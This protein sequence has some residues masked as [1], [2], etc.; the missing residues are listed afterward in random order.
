M[1]EMDLVKERIGYL[2]VWIGIM[3]IANISL[4]GWLIS[5]F[6]TSDKSIVFF[7]L[8]AII[9]VAVGIMVL[10]NLINNRINLLRGL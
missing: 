2:K 5:H 6:H 7:C 1:A 8:C 10:H 4:F 9:A 3:I